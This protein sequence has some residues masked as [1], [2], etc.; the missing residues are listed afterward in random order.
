[1]HPKIVSF[2]WI[3][4][5]SSCAVGQDFAN[6]HHYQEEN[7]II[8]E[9]G[10]I[11][12]TVIIGDSITARWP[13]IRPHFFEQTKL[14]GR[15]ISGETTPQMLLRFRQDV[16]DLQPKTVIILGGTN[17]LAGNSGNVSTA[18]TLGYLQS[19]VELAKQND[20]SPVLCS[21][22]PADSFFWSTAENPASAIQVL[23]RKIRAYAERNNLKYI[24]FH[25]IMQNRSSGIRTSFSDDGV[26]PNSLGYSAM[27][28][29]L[30]S[31]L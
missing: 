5:I 10:L 24:D 14:V 28:R 6:L 29:L 21:I 2:V 27:E 19:M 20:I 11:I 3:C 15:G 31:S 23:N 30:Q 16:I 13:R 25:S 12:D 18:S 1:M 26:H 17:D 9:E 8:V 7:R 22:L 4:L